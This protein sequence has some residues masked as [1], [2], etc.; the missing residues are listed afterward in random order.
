MFQYRNL[1]SLSFTIMN[2]TEI[3][4][5]IFDLIQ[6][7]EGSNIVLMLSDQNVGKTTLISSLIFGPSTLRS[8]QVY[9]PSSP[10]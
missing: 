4:L 8:L 7:Y 1:Q 2:I 5:P 9:D 3:L 6:Q 10:E